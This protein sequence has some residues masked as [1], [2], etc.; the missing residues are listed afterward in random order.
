M[1]THI[2]VTDMQPYAK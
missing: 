2:S 1:G